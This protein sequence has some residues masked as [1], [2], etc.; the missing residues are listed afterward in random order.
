MCLILDILT[1]DELLFVWK[2]SILAG[3]TINLVAKRIRFSFS[4]A[5]ETFARPFGKV[6]IPTRAAS[7]IYPLV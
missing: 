6:L 4:R 5:V 2:D 7:T 3:K 1:I